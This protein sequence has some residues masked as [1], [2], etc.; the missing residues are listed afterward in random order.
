MAFGFFVIV[1][2]ERPYS[3]VERFDGCRVLTTFKHF[4]WLPVIPR[5]SFVRSETPSGVREIAIGIHWVSVLATCAR[6]WGTIWLS[7]CV[8]ALLA[9]ARSFVLGT[10]IWLDLVALCAV[11]LWGFVLAGRISPTSAAQRRVYARL[12]GAP[13][14]VGRYSPAQAHD[15]REDLLPALVDGARPYRFDYRSAVDARLAWREIALH[16]EVRDRDYLEA[17]L[18]RARLETPW[19]P[20]GVERR[21]MATAHERIWRKLSGSKAACPVCACP[22]P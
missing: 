15:L 19:S 2:G 20:R 7:A 3:S 9:G 14:D 10:T 4:Y 22:T 8:I 5:H 11:V 21:A 18:T 12:T 16:D 17:A 1:S 13:V 6:I